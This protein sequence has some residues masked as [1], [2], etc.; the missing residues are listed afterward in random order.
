MCIWEVLFVSVKGE[1]WD[2]RGEGWGRADGYPFL[3]PPPGCRT[4]H[5]LASRGGWLHNQ[6]WDVCVSGRDNVRTLRAWWGLEMC[7]MLS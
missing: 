2:R 3:G 4:P 6:L 7:K 1:K 5:P